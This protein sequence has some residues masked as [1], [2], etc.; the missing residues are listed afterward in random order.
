MV[1]VTSLSESVVVLQLRQKI[2]WAL[3]VPF[4]WLV[5]CGSLGMSWIQ[6]FVRCLLGGFIGML[7]LL[8]ETREMQLLIA[9]LEYLRQPC[10]ERMLR[11]IGLL[12]WLPVVVVS[13]SAAA[14]EA[15][16]VR[17][18]TVLRPNGFDRHGEHLLHAAA[19]LDNVDPAMFG[20]FDH[21]LRTKASWFLSH[22]LVWHTAP[23]SRDAGLGVSG[24]PHQEL[25]QILDT[26]AAGRGPPE[27]TSVFRWL[28]WRVGR[29]SSS[30]RRINSRR[31]S[32][33]GQLKELS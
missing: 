1:A 21:F 16:K 20:E 4:A 31:L 19:T 6:L 30:S 12:V 13:E 26:A 25:R 27:L 32:K 33:G 3:V 5:I 11:V 8:R 24:G 7:A 23:E 28:Q 2:P 10:D 9:L 18:L 14:L 15:A 17:E 22:A 29:L